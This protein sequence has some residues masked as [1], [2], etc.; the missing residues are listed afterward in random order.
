MRTNG[1]PHLV[2]KT[3]RAVR[4]N[5]VRLDGTDIQERELQALIHDNPSLLPVDEF[6]GDF[7]P[8]IPLGRE[9]LGIDNLFISPSGKLTVVEAKLWRNPQAT[10]TVLAQVLDYA[11]RLA[12]LSYEGLETA[13]RSASQSELS[14]D[15][16][17]HQFVSARNA[18]A[19]PPEATFVDRV[20]RN[21]RNGRFLL[22]VV[23]DGI[24]E[25]LEQILEALHHQSR[26]HFTFGLVELKIYQAPNEGG[27][28]VIPSVVAHS[29]EVERAVVTIRGAHTNQV[30]VDVRA[31]PAE[32]APKLTERE[33]LESIEDPQTRQL[34][35]R[36]FHWARQHG[37]IEITK[38]GD[39][40]SVRIPFSS[41]TAGLILIRLDGS[42]R[43][44]TTPPRLRR[45][46]ERIG[47]GGD[48][49]IRLARELQEVIPGIRIE[50]EKEQVARFI[51]ASELLPHLDEALAIYEQA[52]ERLRALETD[53]ET[54]PD[55]DADESS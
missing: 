46:L 36:L 44:L 22:L 6:D 17:L 37:H 5:R 52:I 25:G 34:G 33:F 13:C 41:T 40:A 31:D 14:P 16:T 45:V 4:L 3:G 12:R 28:L 24:R 54:S 55:E 39:S 21:L 20:Q 32:Q 26:L 7:G 18:G 48:E 47:V 35:E 38:K 9:V 29:T 50:P 10:R 30:E 27:Q 23:G 42:G 2:G 51:R 8:L 53:L 1:A 19:V 15:T 49:V 43:V 11:A